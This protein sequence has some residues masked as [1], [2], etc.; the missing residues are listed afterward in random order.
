MKKG[1]V[2][3]MIGIC[4]VG[5]GSDAKKLGD[6]PEHVAWE[7]QVAEE[8]SQ[9]V[10]E[11]IAKEDTEEGAESVSGN[12]ISGDEATEAEPEVFSYK[13]DPINEVMYCVDENGVVQASDGSRTDGYT[14]DGTNV[15][16]EVGTKVGSISTMGVTDYMNQKYM[17]MDYEHLFQ[18]YGWDWRPVDISKLEFKEFEPSRLVYGYYEGP[19]TEECID[20]ACIG[21]DPDSMFTSV[22]TILQYAFDSDIVK[23]T[24]E[25][26]V[27]KNG[28]LYRLTYRGKKLYKISTEVDIDGTFYTFFYEIKED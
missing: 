20:T 4:L 2:I 11:E 7:M 13:G 17:Q 23:V 21:E 15:F 14:T 26:A 1:L 12:T 28:S 3:L 18:W 24:D 8:N 16:N 5:C 9:R 10:A 19:G 22:K 6:D 27:T 25:G